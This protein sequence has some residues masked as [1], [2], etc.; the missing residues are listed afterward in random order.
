MSEIENPRLV[1]Y[2]QLVD[3]AE[4]LAFWL[5]VEGIRVT[6]FSVSLVK[7]IWQA[8][9]A[10]LSEHVIQTAVQIGEYRGQ[11]SQNNVT[12]EHYPLLRTPS[13]NFIPEREY[14]PVVWVTQ[15]QLVEAIAD[16]DE[17]I[18]QLSDLQRADL[19]AS[20][21]TA[22]QQVYLTLLPDIIISCLH[23]L[24]NDD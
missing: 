11:I 7:A 8:L 19:I 21:G 20:L 5:G 6:G 15:E 17:E 23:D 18:D 13:K 12:G 4:S 14:H 22:M 16:F 1:S 2:F 9:D 10:G 3:Q 24:A